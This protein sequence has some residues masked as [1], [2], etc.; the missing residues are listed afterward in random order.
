MTFIEHSIC[1]KYFNTH[2]KEQNF[3]LNLVL[4][5]FGPFRKKTQ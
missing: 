3:Y 2:Y 4:D 1:V 5:N